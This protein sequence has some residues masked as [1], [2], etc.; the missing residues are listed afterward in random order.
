LT[1]D[2]T[3]QYIYTA[4]Q[5][6]GRISQSISGGQTVNYTYDSL[7]RLATAQATDGSW[8]NAYSYDGFGNLT[9]KTVTAGSAPN[10][11]VSYDP[12]TNRGGYPYGSTNF[13]ANGNQL[14]G[15]LDPASGNWMG[16]GYDVENRIVGAG[17]NGGS[18]TVYGYD[19]QGKRVLQQTSSLGNPTSTGSQNIVTSYGFTF[20]G[21]TGQRLSTFSVLASQYGNS[22]YCNGARSCT[23]GGSGS[24]LYFGGRLISN[25]IGGVMTDRL[26]SVRS[27]ISYYPWGEEKTSPPTQD[28]QVKFGTY[29]RDMPG[30]D[31]ADQ[32]YYTAI[33]G[34]FYTPDPSTGVD[35]KNPITWNKYVYASGDPVNR[36]DPTG[37]DDCTAWEFDSSLVGDPCGS[38]DP[39]SAWGAWFPNIPGCGD[40]Q[41]NQF[42]PGIGMACLALA[43]SLPPQQPPPPP[44]I[45]C[46]ATLE[47][48]TVNLKVNKATIRATHAF[49]DLT[50]IDFNSPVTVVQDDIISAGPINGNLNVFIHGPNDPG[51]ADTI[52]SGKV[53]WDSGLSS[54]S[55]SGVNRI[56][57][58]AKSWPNDS[59]PYGGLFGPNS[60]SVA[61]LL[62]QYGGFNPPPPPRSLGWNYW[63]KP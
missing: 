43:A 62:G 52:Y 40:I 2:G 23:G 55:C 51:A 45:E 4:G 3:T 26:G 27:G 31:Y 15:P 6:N 12:A 7:N 59:I 28:G 37:T 9:A 8:G 18:S 50:E 11:S 44:V 54:E 46:D 63:L 30:Q 19:P 21:I 24:W 56:L 5:N 41:P 22:G 48:R 38:G 42:N 20:Y 57:A 14:Y 58:Y 53:S 60:N 16:Y 29:F 34:R 47:Y 36:V 32:R 49:W 10:F 39:A 17:S 33:A 61:G 35:P 13:D 1:G 25:S